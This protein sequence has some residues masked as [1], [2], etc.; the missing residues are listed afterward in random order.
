[1]IPDEPLAFADVL[2][3]FRVGA[4]LSQE[5]LAECARL[6]ARGISDLERGARRVP[7]LQTVR[8]LADALR[9]GRDERDALFEAARPPRVDLP[10]HAHAQLP[11]RSYVPRPPTSL[12]G[13]ERELDAIVELLTCGGSRLLTLTGPG[14]V[15]KTRLALEVIPRLLVDHP[16]GAQLVDLAAI[17]DAS[18]VDIA[19]ARTLGVHVSSN[20][21]LLAALEDFLYNKRLL[22]VL[23]NTEHVAAGAGFLTRLVAT[24]PGVTVLT[25]SRTPLR[26]RGERLLQV[27]PLGVPDKRA[28][29]SLEEISSADSVR[30]FV[31]R[32]RDIRPEFSLGEA[33]AGAVAEIC[34][35]LDGLPLALELAAS[36]TAILPP[37]TLVHK[38]DRILPLLTSDGLD[39][40]ERHR[41]LRSAIAWS[42]NLLS[43]RQQLMF[44]RLG[45]FSGGWTL[46]AAA[47]VTRTDG[48]SELDVID[49]LESLVRASLV[50]ETTGPD[51]ALRFAMLGTTREFAREQLDLGGESREISAR[52]AS[53]V[54]SLVPPGI[55]RDRDTYDWWQRLVAEH[56]NLGEALAWMRDRY[57]PREG[58]R[59]AATLGPYWRLRS[60]HT[61]GRSWLETF[62]GSTAGDDQV[63]RERV[64]ALRWAGELAALHGDPPAADRY[65]SESLAHARG[66]DDKRGVAAALG[67]TASALI[68]RGDVAESARYLLEAL[69]VAREVDDRRQTASLLVRQAF[70]VGH[71]GDP[72]LGAA[73]ADESLT[74]LTALR[75]T[76]GF[77]AAALDMV[78]GWLALMSGMTAV[79]SKKLEMAITHGRLLGSK[80][81]LSAALAG[82]GEA[83]LRQG[84][85][86]QATAAYRDG[87]VMGWEGDYPLGIVLNMQGLVRIAVQQGE[88]ARAARMAGGVERFGGAIHV[89]PDIMRDQYEYANLVARSTLDDAPF[90]AEQMIGQAM[91]CEELVSQGL[92]MR[93]SCVPV[94]GY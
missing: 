79:A 58:L 45:V 82:L 38:L 59:L 47:Y 25:T 27:P 26:L 46:Q 52:H 66:M 56:A 65:L 19:L 14:G 23:D 57:R 87:L 85:V 63:M 88:L 33:N 8:M 75:A 54:L 64:E 70:V 43:P 48:Q 53:Y 86:T 7:R 41:T 81:V 31:E 21:P 16:D 30:L 44:R 69:D 9:L 37:A 60:A 34:R 90:L 42:Y 55:G 77:E 80:A 20:G 76:R 92:R 62:L 2:K 1:M 71:Q 67:A 18:L 91:R 13:R 84:Q 50:Q 94:L 49:D 12:V 11:A 28:D 74:L 36:R 78:Q 29:R 17:S 51:R 4:G 3:T 15:G 10:C 83:T 68:H 22:L 24:C 40:P 72:E 89:L 5:Q 35:R 6:S 61:E 39:T 32:V 93:P 73:L